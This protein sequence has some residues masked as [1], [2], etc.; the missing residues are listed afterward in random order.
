[1]KA[2]SGTSIKPSPS[3]VKLFVSSSPAKAGGILDYRSFS[4]VTK[5]DRKKVE[6]A[7]GCR[8]YLQSEYTVLTYPKLADKRFKDLKV[9][10]A[11]EESVEESSSPSDA[12]DEPGNDDI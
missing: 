12:K 10:E 4:S 8:Y 5:E 6:A 2:S 7:S 9:L 3:A 11:D 1:M